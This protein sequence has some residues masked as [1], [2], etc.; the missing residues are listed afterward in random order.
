YATDK[1]GQERVSGAGCTFAAAVTAELAKGADIHDAARIAKQA[2][3]QGILER[4][5]S[6]APFDAVWFDAQ[7]NQE[8]A[9]AVQVRVL[10]C[11]PPPPAP[12]AASGG[13][14]LAERCIGRRPAR[15][16]L[17]CAEESRLLPHNSAPGGGGVVEGSARGRGAAPGPAQKPPPG[18]PSVAA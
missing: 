14:P 11:G 12:S 3:I 13:G 10:A 2:V 18:R 5:T 4:R 8:S 9:D 7:L 6:A 17:R 1:I 15:R 16:T